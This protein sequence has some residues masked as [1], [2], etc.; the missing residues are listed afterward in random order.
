VDGDMG[1]MGDLK[2]FG[3]EDDGVGGGLGEGLGP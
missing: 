2:E 1:E 3:C